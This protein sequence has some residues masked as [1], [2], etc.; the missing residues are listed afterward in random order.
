M[1]AN[2]KFQNGKVY[3]IHS[4]SA[5]LNYIGSTCKTLSKRLIDHRS[6]FNRYK[7]DK[8]DVYI[9]S[10]EVLEYPD[11]CILLI[12]NFPCENKKELEQREGDFIKSV[13]CVNE[14]VAGRTGN[15]SSKEYYKKNKEQIL[16]RKKEY[17]K[18]NKEKVKEK[19]KIYNEQNKEKILEQ[20]KEYR[21]KNKEIIKE[22]RSRPFV[23]ECGSIVQLGHKSHHM[24]TKKHQAWVE[25]QSS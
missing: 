3:R 9:T 16:A 6:A 11:A 15:E 20:T 22:R 7:D 14:R 25:S 23:C 21:Q 2:N 5:N 8:G 13:E 24:Q 12:E 17:K 1:S 10:F 18:Q 19:N 4:P